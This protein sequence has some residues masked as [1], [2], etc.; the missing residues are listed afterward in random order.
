MSENPNVNVLVN[1]AY[2]AATISLGVWT[3]SWVMKK[4]LK[5]KP[6]NL[7][8]L[9]AED[10]GKLTLSVLSAMMLRDLLVKQG[11]LPE[12]IMTG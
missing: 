1:S 10:L 3:N 7:S 6:A 4:F 2:H 5:I 9:D 11:I 12:D 8:Q